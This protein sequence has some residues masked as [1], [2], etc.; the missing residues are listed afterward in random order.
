MI[1]YYG[2]GATYHRLALGRITLAACGKRLSIHLW[3][4]GHRA[5]LDAGGVF[6]PCRRCFASDAV[7]PDA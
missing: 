2:P 6:K 1:V 4:R 5:E 3:K 7:Q